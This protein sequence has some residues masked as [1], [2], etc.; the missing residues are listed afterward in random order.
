MS[1]LKACSFANFPSLKTSKGP[2]GN[3][4]KMK[5]LSPSFTFS[6]KH[7]AARIVSGPSDPARKAL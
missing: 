7:F 5:T 2:T 3:P 6:P 1:L 4:V